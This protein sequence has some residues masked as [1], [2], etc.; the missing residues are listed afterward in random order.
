[1]SIVTPIAVFF[2]LNPDE[3]LTARDIGAKW[4]VEPNNVGNT[5]RY[6]EKKGWVSSTMK[7]NPLMPSKKI[8]FYAAG[9][10]LR[11]EIGL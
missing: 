8:K 4:G 5:L 1:M 11:R 9:P 10:R 3:E 6:A 2:A 7:P